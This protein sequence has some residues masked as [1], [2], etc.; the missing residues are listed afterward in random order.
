MIPTNA[1][2][3]AT[4]FFKRKFG[5]TAPYTVQAPARVELLGNHNGYNQGLVMLL[6]VDRFLC[7][8]GSPRTDGKICLT[9][10]AFGS[11]TFSAGRIEKNP[12]APWA[13]YVKGVVLELR[14]HG[15]AVGGFNAA[16]H[17]TIPMGA[18][19]GS[20][21]ALTVA[22]ALLLRKM[23]PYVVTETGSTQPPARDRA[24][25]APPFTPAQKLDVARLCQTAEQQYA[26][27]A[28]GLP[29][30]VAPLFGKAFHVVQFDCRDGVV[31]HLLMAGEIVVVICPSGI[32]PSPAARDHRPWRNICQSAARALRVQSLRQV[33]ARRLKANRA[34]LTDHEYQCAYHVVGENQR[35]VFGER[36]L[37]ADDFEQFGQFMFQSHA[38]SRELFHNSCAELDLLVDL[39]RRHS[40]CLGARLS[41][42]GFGGATVNLVRLEALNDFKQ[43]M[44]RGYQQACHRSMDPL[45]C[46]I[47]DGAE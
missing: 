13:D 28:C 8:A 37:R 31:E 22:A 44:A 43:F 7:M 40:G 29:D 39:A 47:V 23:Y 6:A 38:S 35:V 11:E 19:L 25:L 16:I 30:H 2:K 24:G 45:I 14:R 26:G 18:G 41:G 1:H 36:A 10:T 27:T 33:D 32:Q 4:Q 42:I 20:S 21:S 9:G 5:F 17:S 46:R 12:S 3:E 34:R 15:V